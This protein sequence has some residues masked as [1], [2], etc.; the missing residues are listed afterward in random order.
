MSEKR[1]SLDYKEGKDLVKIYAVSDIHL[2][3]NENQQWFY[4]L[5]PFAYQN[6]VLILAGDVIHS[7]PELKK[8]FMFLKG[9]FKDIVYVPGNHELWVEKSE[10]YDSLEKFDR[11]KGIADLCGIHMQPVTY[12]NVTIVPLFGWYDY[13]FGKPSTDLKMKW[14]DYFTCQWPQGFDEV[15]ITRHFCTL[16]KNHMT[17]INEQIISFSHFLPRIDLMPFYIPS[18]KQ[19][20]YPVLGS[21]LLEQQIRQLKSSIHIFGHSHVNRSIIKNGIH[22]IN[23]AYGYPYESNIAAKKLLCCI[24]T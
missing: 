19:T 21:F 1:N 24:K 15:K 14:N 20:L 12:G 2:D 16:N 9:I 6:D 4:N 10:N 22:Y 8:A 13:S 3:F 11:I 18:N 5:S 23:N 17:C 7:L